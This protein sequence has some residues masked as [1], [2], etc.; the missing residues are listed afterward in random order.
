MD[1]SDTT[2]VQRVVLLELA[3][4]ETAVHAGEL[5]RRCDERL[6]AVDADIVGRVSEAEATRA[7][8]ELHAD[9]LVEERDAT[10]TS[11]VGKGRP[12]YAIDVD[13]GALRSTL[14]DDG[15]LDALLD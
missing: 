9:G 11:P 2:L 13:P 3:R 4:V 7:L 8:N 12:A 1:I 5:A 15:R 10:D 6:T 14:A